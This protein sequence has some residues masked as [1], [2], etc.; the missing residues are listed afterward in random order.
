MISCD[1][2]QKKMVALFDNEGS[3]GHDA[4]MSTHLKDCPECR[5][6]RDDMV[7]IRR[8]FVSAPVPSPPAAMAQ[9]VMSQTA[10]ERPQTG[11]SHPKKT[12]RYQPWRRR[13]LRLAWASALMGLSSIVLSRLIYLNGAREVAHLR[14]ELQVAQRDLAMFRAEKQLR[15]VEETQE[16]EQRAITALYLRMGELERRLDRDY[17][18]RTAFLPTEG[19][20]PY[21]VFPGDGSAL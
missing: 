17:S 14:S 6:F 21:S 1:E 3:E 18:P 12:G 19:G 11:T 4:L 13:F 9:E 2:C 16:K 20:H 5:A 10:A 15:E 8:A 7:E